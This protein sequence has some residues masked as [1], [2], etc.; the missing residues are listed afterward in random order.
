VNAAGAECPR[1]STAEATVTLDVTTDQVPRVQNFSK[2]GVTYSTSAVTEV[3]TVVFSKAADCV[4]IA[5]GTVTYAAGASSDE[6]VGGPASNAK[7]KP[8]KCQE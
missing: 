5:Q 2:A 3:F 1:G 6:I 7:V 4:A 8:L